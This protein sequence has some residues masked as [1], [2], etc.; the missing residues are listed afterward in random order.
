MFDLRGVDCLLLRLT[1]IYV[2]LVVITLM[3]VVVC[4]SF[5][6]CLGFSLMYVGLL[7]GLMWLVWFT[8]GFD[9]SFVLFGT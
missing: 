8:L 9:L 4:F 7:F 1:W 2:C 3:L 5:P 6:V